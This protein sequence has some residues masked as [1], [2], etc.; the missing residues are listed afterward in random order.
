MEMLME[1]PK[2]VRGRYQVRNRNLRLNG[3][4]NPPHEFW[5]VR[6]SAD[7]RC[8]IETT[9]EESFWVSCD[10]IAHALSVGWITPDPRDRW[11]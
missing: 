4:G 10:E 11:L 9:E 6:T 7:G 5:V 1:E 2:V 3:I 8:L